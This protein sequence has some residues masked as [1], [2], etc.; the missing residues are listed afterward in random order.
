MAKEVDNTKIVLQPPQEP[1][2]QETKED[3]LHKAVAYSEEII[4]QYICWLTDTPQNELFPD[5]CQAKLPIVFKKGD[6]ELWKLTLDLVPKN[7][8]F[9]LTASKIP[10]VKEK[11]QALAMSTQFVWLAI[12]KHLD[13][14]K[15]NPAYEGLIT[16]D[17]KLIMD[18]GNSTMLAYNLDNGYVLR[19]KEKRIGFKWEIE[20]L[21]K[22]D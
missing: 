18:P 22:K 10:L 12:I 20:K 21:N 7:E 19:D 2:Q 15:I 6:N 17:T 14:S 16:N 9:D 4:Q 1:E 8:Q 5:G 3:I 13:I 11:M